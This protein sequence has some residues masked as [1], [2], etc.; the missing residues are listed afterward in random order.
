MGLQITVYLAVLFFIVDVY[1]F[2]FGRVLQSPHPKYLIG[3]GHV[4]AK[5]LVN[6]EKINKLML[7]IKQVFEINYSKTKVAVLR[8]QQ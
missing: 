2:K 6:I 7:R 3:L 1:N 5:G 8:K 4:Y